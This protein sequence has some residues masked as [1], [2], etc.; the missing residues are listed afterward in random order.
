MG[1]MC[2]TYITSHSFHQ[3]LPWIPFTNSAAELIQQEKL[4][5]KLWLEQKDNKYTVLLQISKTF[6]DHLKW[7][8]QQKEACCF[9]SW[10]NH[11]ALISFREMKRTWLSFSALWTLARCPGTTLAFH[12]HLLGSKSTRIPCCQLKTCPIQQ[13]CYVNAL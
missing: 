13:C 9:L 11:C 1:W 12:C 2:V 7:S 5:K 10:K 3:P 6:P 8:D 4:K